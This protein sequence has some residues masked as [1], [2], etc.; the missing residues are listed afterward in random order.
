MGVEVPSNPINRKEQYLAK[1]AGQAVEIPAEP[2]TREEAYL[3]EIAKNGSGGGGGTSNYEDLENKPQIA[4]TTL[5][6]NKSL[7]DLGIA[8]AQ[9]ISN[10]TNGESIN[11]FAGVETALDGVE[12]ALAG[13]QPTLTFDDTP[14]DGS[15]NPVKS[16]GIYDA[17]ALK[18]NAT[19]NSLDTD[20][21]TIVGAINE[22]EGDIA[23][24]KSGLTNLDNEVNGDATTYPY[25]DVITIKDAVPA[26]LAACSV[27]IEP[28]QDLHGYDK[29]WVGGAGKNKLPPIEPTSDG[30]ASSGTFQLKAGSYILSFTNSSSVQLQYWLNGTYVSDTADH[31]VNSGA[32]PSLNFT[33]TA[34]DTVS[35]GM[36]HNPQDGTFSVND[37]SYEMIRLSTESSDYAP[38]T[39]ICPISGHTESAVTRCS[40]NVWDEQWELGLYDDNT[41]EKKASSQRIRNTNYI[42]VLP[43]QKYYIYLPSTLNDDIKFLYYDK[44]KRYI[45]VSE[46]TAKGEIIIPQNVCYINF[47]VAMNYGTTYNNDISINNPY[48][49]AQYHPYAGKIYTLALGDTIYG[50]EVN[51]NTGVMTV[52]HKYVD[53]GDYTWSYNNNNS[54]Y[55]SGITDFAKSSSGSMQYATYC[56][57]DKY[58]FRIPG[59]TT[60]IQLYYNTSYSGYRCFVFDDPNT[61]EFESGSAFK[62]YIAGTHIC[63][64]LNDASKFT[65]QLTPTQIQLLKGTNT[66]SA[67]TGQISVT[68]NGVS[69]AIGAVQTQANATDNALA[70]LAADIA[71]QLPDAPTTDGTYVLTV[72]VADGT[73]T[74]SWE[75]AT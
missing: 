49:D 75:S 10:I 66:I 56:I 50:G 33:V 60:Q 30:Y 34:D 55:T 35:L 67:S 12:T 72:T 24:L 19:D 65:I 39:N 41:G 23:T 40:V 61:S 46:W 7:A 31:F 1:I 20:A 51:P 68:V 9:S 21:K 13:K 70:Q 2:L 58:P 29:P 14:T 63:Y 6:G 22:H 8:S 11:N 52:T 36:R 43:L 42:R 73:P 25:A 62:A 48:T 47:Y 53:L 28:V 26:N 16:N 15:N 17:L 59:G 27:K 71:E 38:Y 37:I 54:F 74:Y 18:Q 64:E 45:G 5:S 44:N 69:G 4:G 3:D 57:S 32:S